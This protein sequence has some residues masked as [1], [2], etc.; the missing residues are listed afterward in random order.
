MEEEGWIAMI[1]KERLY[2]NLQKDLEDTVE[3]AITAAAKRREYHC[4]LDITGIDEII[5]VPVIGELR[6]GGFDVGE[7]DVTEGE[8]SGTTWMHI[9]W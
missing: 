5:T 2:K 4:S 3:A 6:E 1:T 9:R 7:E 8:R